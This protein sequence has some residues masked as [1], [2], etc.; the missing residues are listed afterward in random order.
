MT[1]MTAEQVIWA[2][3]KDTGSKVYRCKDHGIFLCI[4][5]KDSRCPQCNKKGAEHEENS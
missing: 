4:N 1:T 2:M 5:S 3:A